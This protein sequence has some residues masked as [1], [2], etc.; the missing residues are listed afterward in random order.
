MPEDVYRI[1]TS[2]PLL[3]RTPSSIQVGIDE[4][5]VIVDDIPDHAAP[6]IHALQSGVSREGFHL[7]ARQLRVPLS[8]ATRMVRDLAP[9][10]DPDLTPLAPRYIVTGHGVARRLV[11]DTL[12]NW[13]ARATLAHQPR[14]STS[15]T[16]HLLVADY[17]IDPEWL[18]VYGGGRSA[19]IPLVFSDRTISAGP[20]V[21]PGITPC[22]S[23]RELFLREREPHWLALG[24]QLWGSTPP[25]ATEPLARVAA[26]LVALSA[27]QIRLTTNHK[28][29]TALIAR[30]HPDTAELTVAEAEFH[31]ECRC[32]GL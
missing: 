17:L 22:L 4:P 7:L 19:H 32:R 11:A 8:D 13:G 1:R 28:P 16:I 2:R 30:F 24:S 18:P 14:P 31:P 20:L 6:L 26:L 9:T 12:R 15:R 21:T 5:A 3:W 27:G 29:E 25:T 23:C 10:F